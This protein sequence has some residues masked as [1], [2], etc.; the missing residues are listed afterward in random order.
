MTRISQKPVPV[1]RQ[2]IKFAR[3]EMFLVL[4]RDPA[5]EMAEGVLEP[6][7]FGTWGAG[8]SIVNNFILV[9]CENFVDKCD[10]TRANE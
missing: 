8:R 3:A 2:P 9:L 6:G 10:V 1:H 4:P 5:R 7:A